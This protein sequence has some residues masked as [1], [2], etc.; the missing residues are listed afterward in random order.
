MSF[1]LVMQ[2]ETNLRCKV[3]IFIIYTK[4]FT[5][6]ANFACVNLASMA[7]LA[8]TKPV[9]ASTRQA[10]NTKATFANDGELNNPDKQYISASRDKDPFWRV[11]LLE[12]Y[13]VTTVEIVCRMD[14]SFDTNDRV[15]VRV[16][17]K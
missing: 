15:E 4:Y 7:N 12:I 8:L 3:G 11:D 13:I 6:S 17:E 14:G 2:K 9:Y 10:T 1:S 16:G 5:L